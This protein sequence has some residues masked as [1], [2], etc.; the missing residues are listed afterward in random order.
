MRRHHSPQIASRFITSLC[1]L[2][3]AAGVYAIPSS[4]QDDLRAATASSKPVKVE[5]LENLPAGSELEPGEASSTD[6][7]TERAFGFV[8]FPTKY[9]PNA[10][11]LDRSVPFVVRASLPQGLPA[12]DYQFRLRARG[13]ARFLIDDK[14]LLT[15]KPQ[16]ANSS[17]NDPV[18]PPAERENSPVRPI[19][20]PHQ[21]TLATIHL[22]GKEHSFTL[23]ALIGGKGLVPSPGELSVSFG[24]E[25]EVPRLLGSDSPVLLTD[26]GWETFAAE[27]LER[28]RAG[29]VMRRQ[30]ISANV[31]AQW[32][33]YHR[34]VRDSISKSEA[35]RLPI[36]KSRELVFNPIDQFVLARLEETRA[37]PTTLTSDLEFFRRLALDTIGTIPTAEEVRTFLSAPATDRRQRAIQYFLNHQGWAEHWVSYW[38]DVLAENPGILKPDLNN[39]GPFRWWLYQSFYDN[40]PFDRLVA[41]LIQMEGSAFQGAPAAFKLATMNDSPM[42]AKADIL[43]QAFLAEKL[44]CARCHDAPDHP[45]KQGDTFGFAAMLEGKPL[46]L[47]ASSTVPFVDGFRKPRIEV[48]LKPGQQVEPHWPYEHLVKSS[49]LTGLIPVS[50]SAPA[51]RKQVAAMIVSPDNERF[52]KVTMNRLWKRYLG[53]GLVEPAEDWFLAKPSHPELLD[54]LAREFV[55]SGYDLKAMARLIFS[56]HVYQRKPLA[57]AAT[58]AE[59]NDRLFAGPMRRRLSAEQLV[60]SLYSASGKSFSCEELNLNPAG[61]RPLNEFLN[62]GSPR[63]AWQF[64]A[65]MNERDRPALALPIAQSIVDV[66]TTFGWRQSRQNP[67]TVRQDAPSAMQTLLLANGIMGTRITRLSDDSTFTELALED[68]P[69]G[70]L[71]DETFL[72]IFT[73]L[74]SENERRAAESYLKA[75]YAERKQKG[76]SKQKASFGSDKR[77]SW[78]NHLSAEATVIR[79]EEERQLRMGDEPTTRLTREFREHYEDLL[80]SLVNSPEFTLIP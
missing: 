78:G 24:R 33:D 72:R 79:M 62:L 9:S 51:T 53:A 47:P 44:S 57:A 20:Y 40:I 67:I 74:P 17:G 26:E 11:P 56:S 39:S 65:L 10:L 19:P 68:R 73:R 29:D 2:T 35:L 12:G 71:I 14:I 70:E 38:Q 80:W 59:P 34:K 6:E 55:L 27:Q 43:S 5:I 45:H 8:R 76:A 4:S 58:I 16:K 69:L 15:T 22:D 52:A 60:D 25:G 13:A 1:F 32:E 49:E 7:Y 31:I 28:H 42:A 66:L 36:V 64:T 48:S 23:I 18:P 3:L 63:R 50:A 37:T 21:E 77:V 41:E 30:T 46:K 75:H 61:N 54:Y